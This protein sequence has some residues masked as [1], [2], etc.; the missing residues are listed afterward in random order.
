MISEII[1]RTSINNHRRVMLRRKERKNRDKE[2]KSKDKT[3]SSS[4]RKSKKAKGD[5]AGA[6]KTRATGD[7]KTGEVRLHE[8]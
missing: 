1:C 7:A 2:K 4:A 8:N 6:L 3:S 5:G